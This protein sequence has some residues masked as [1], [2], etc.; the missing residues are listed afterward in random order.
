MIEEGIIN[1]NKNRAYVEKILEQ[2]KNEKDLTP[3]PPF[4][5]RGDVKPTPSELEK[6]L[7]DTLSSLTFKIE[8]KL[9]EEKIKIGI[10][11]GH[12]AQ[13]TK[14]FFDKFKNVESEIIGEVELENLATLDK[15]DCLFIMQG[16]ITEN[17]YFINIPHY[18]KEGGRGVLFQHDL[19]GY[20]RS[21]FGQRT[22]FPEIVKYG[23]DR[24]DVKY[25]KDGDLLTAVV[26][27]PVLNPL[28]KGD[29]GRHLYYD[30]ITAIPGD[31]GI[32]L[33]IDTNKSPV[34]V[35]G[36]S[37]KGKVIFDG[38]INLHLDETEK[39]LSGINA[40]ITKGAVEWFTGKK[41]I[42]K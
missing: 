29:S 13:A 20:V 21:P 39:E 19:I 27:H 9:T 33:L 36:L 40:I 18:V 1:F 11:R 35:A 41:L 15:Y 2:T 34:V 12:G 32:V 26:D 31:E 42:E 22:P 10:L 4:H 5:E 14:Q 30:H 28:K 3:F 24:V 25:V 7:K 16:N 6:M 8:P 38:T 37:G 17:A 23:K